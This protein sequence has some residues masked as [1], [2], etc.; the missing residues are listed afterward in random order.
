MKFA[1]CLLILALAASPARSS[2]GQVFLTWEDCDRGGA[3]T[4]DAVAVCLTNDNAN[5]LYCSFVLT[6]PVDD[7]LGI[8]VTVDLQ[9]SAGTLPDWWQLDGEGQCR[10]GQLHVSGDYTQSYS[11][12]D[13]WH[14]RGEGTAIYYPAPAAGR[15]RIV[16]T[17]AVRQDSAATLAAGTQYYG[18]TI[19]I[20]N[21]R[22]V[23]PG[24]CAGCNKPACLVLNTIK[25]LR[26]PNSV[27][28]EVTIDDSGP[29]GANR[30][31][32]LGG[33]GADCAAVP[34]RAGTWGQLKNL[35]R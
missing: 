8:E 21:D 1:G 15:A 35:Y 32:W 33:A 31:T 18:L 4:H 25:L 12:A 14:D 27:P 17:Y 34:A 6:Q 16:G 26:G 13:P 24:Q 9:N 28:R 2:E 19:V 20:G 23:Y 3:G 22:T 30:A 29:S 7:V 10:D 5:Y 11:C